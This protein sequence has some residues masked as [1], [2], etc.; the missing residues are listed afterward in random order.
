[1]EKKALSVGSRA[2]VKHPLYVLAW[3][4]RSSLPSFFTFRDCVEVRN[5][6]GFGDHGLATTRNCG[7]HALAVEDR[8]SLYNRQVA[9]P[10][11]AQKGSIQTHAWRTFSAWN[12]IVAVERCA[13]RTWKSGGID[14]QICSASRRRS[15]QGNRRVGM[16]SK[17][18][19]ESLPENM[20][21]PSCGAIFDRQFPSTR[22]LISTCRAACCRGPV[23]HSCHPWLCPSKLTW[24]YRQPPICL[25]KPSNR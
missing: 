1:M 18:S 12:K 7:I 23:R 5:K 20:T 14:A 4:S 9:G 17:L 22:N 19:F 2:T 25:L 11:T 6:F 3:D 21:A 13:Q 16:T 24:S 8:K 10:R 15:F